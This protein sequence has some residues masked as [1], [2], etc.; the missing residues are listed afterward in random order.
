MR[1]EGLE[2]A[3]ALFA[4]VYG[5][6]W[7]DFLMADPDFCAAYGLA[8]PAEPVVEQWFAGGRGSF[9]EEQHAEIAL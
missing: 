4:P 6:P 2:T 9:I 7:N 1:S 8:P 3:S 5:L